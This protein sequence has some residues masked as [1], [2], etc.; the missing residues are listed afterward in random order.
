VWTVEPL[1]A[2]AEATIP[3]DDGGNWSWP[4]LGVD[5]SG[6]AVATWNVAGSTTAP[7][8]V[9]TF[10]ST[11]LATGWSRRVLVGAFAGSSCSG[12]ALQATGLPTAGLAWAA[13]S[14]ELRIRAVP[15]APQAASVPQVQLLT[16][17]WASIRAAGAIEFACQAAADGVCHL[18]LLSA[19][20]DADTLDALEGF[21]RPPVAAA[22]LT[23][24]AHRGVVRFPLDRG[25]YDGGP[26]PALRTGTLT[27]SVLAVQDEVGRTSTSQT[28]PLQ[29]TG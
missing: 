1:D 28:V 10:Q 15:A 7:C 26:V 20:R 23:G 16:T 27:F 19:E 14:K 9:E 13:S 2:L 25:C 24:A 17:T 5:R 4:S 18:S 11:H 8:G 3:Y 6:A 21:C 29:V 22:N 12:S